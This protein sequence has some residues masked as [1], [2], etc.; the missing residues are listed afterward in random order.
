[1]DHVVEDACVVSRGPVRVAN[2]R[3]AVDD[4]FRGCCLGVN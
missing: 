3:P 2:F 4:P 1:M